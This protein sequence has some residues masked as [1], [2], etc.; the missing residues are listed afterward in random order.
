MKSRLFNL[1]TACLKSILKLF[2]N[3]IFKV[4][5][6]GLEN[7]PQD[8]GALIIANH[9]SFLDN[10]ILATS[11]KRNIGFVMTASVYRHPMLNW[12]L[13]RL[14]MVPI[15]TGKTQDYLETFNADC[16][17]K[18]NQGN[19]V[20]IFAEG[21]ISRNGHLLAFKK[22]FEHVA[23][24]LNPDIEIIPI[25]LDGLIG[26]PLSYDNINK[27]TNKFKFKNLFKTVTLTV[28]SP[29]PKESTA[30]ELRQ[31]MKEL[32]VQNF[33][34]R[35]SNSTTLI[36]LA[37]KNIQKI[38]GDLEQKT[39]VDLWNKA[40]DFAKKNE[41]T[42]AP[43]NLIGIYTSS[44]EESS[45][46]NI[47]LTLLGKQ[48]YNLNKNE[49]DINCIHEAGIEFILGLSD[50]DFPSTPIQVSDKRDINSFKTQNL[51]KITKV[52][53]F[54]TSRDYFDMTHENILA[55]FLSLKQL[56]AFK[57]DSCILCQYQNNTAIGY[58]IRV[59]SPLLVGS[60]VIE[61]A[62]QETANVLIGD[63]SFINSYHKQNGSN[64][65]RS[66]ILLDGTE[67][68][69]CEGFNLKAVYQGLKSNSPCPV[70]TLSSPD[71]VGI[72]LG[73]KEITQ[74]GRKK[75]TVG[76]PLPGVAIKIVNDNG[77]NLGTETYGNILAKGALFS[78]KGWIKTGINGKITDDGFLVV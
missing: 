45:I 1:L 57:E 30:F 23:K 5:V 13:K 50:L 75:E 29:L 61:S 78:E 42:L 70:L 4:E 39:S 9:V 6:K 34:D 74:V 11:I 33:S 63:S 8:K 59:W 2:V 68:D 27:K 54:N 77:T 25:H 71:Y 41:S 56:F 46:T 60:K 48:A 19:L 43:Y 65:L 21:Q 66:V 16:Q 58:F 51:S 52:A 20:C 31:K 69:L 26:T 72:A 36:A 64:H 53:K 73:G 10:L 24:G 37:K 14:P 3:I 67:D 35:I 32:E 76:R 38:S 12:L 49:L 15:E 62:D 18:I 17:K 44:Q 28:G 22:G 55:Y 47:A 40:N 7:I